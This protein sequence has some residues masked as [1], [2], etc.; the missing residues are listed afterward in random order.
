MRE[1][2]TGKLDATLEDTP[3]AA[4]Y[5]PRFPALAPVGEPVSEGYYVIYVKKGEPALLQALN[6]AIIAT[7][8]NGEIEGIYRKYGIWDSAQ[9]QLASIAE[10]SRFYGYYRTTQT[11]AR[12]RSDGRRNPWSPAAR[13]SGDG[14]SCAT[15]AGFCCNRPG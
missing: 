8:R 6:E 4:F 14:A 12:A 5:A 11:E 7:I 15:T 13:P 2:E 10:T 3:I 9:G 1:V